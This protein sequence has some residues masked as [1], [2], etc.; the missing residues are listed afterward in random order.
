MSKKISI[1]YAH[2]APRR[3]RVNKY[4]IQAA[5]SV[6]AVSIRDLYELYP[7]MVV[8]KDAEQQALI[9]SAV[10][11][12]HFPMYWF[13]S[14]ALLKEWQDTVFSS[15]FAF[16]KG[17]ALAG[18]KFMLCVTT[19]VAQDS[20]SPAGRHGDVL[21]SYLAPFKQT[22]SFC[23]MEVLE[24]FTIQGTSEL[25]EGEVA[26]AAQEYIMKLKETLGI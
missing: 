5:R 7:N 15:G 17:N 19:G 8:S 20:Y 9:E 26:V 18:K 1:I 25:T 12:F 6:E 4:L 2:P 16:G 22:A 10:I 23:G 3:S 11:V 13:S 21:C 14:P 24:S